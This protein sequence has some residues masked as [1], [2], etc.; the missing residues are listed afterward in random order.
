[1]KIYRFSQNLD[2]IQSLGVPPD[3]AE[4]ILQ[5]V[6]DTPKKKRSVLL[7]KIKK[8]PTLTL[9]QL[10]AIPLSKEDVAKQKELYQWAASISRKYAEWL[11]RMVNKKDLNPE[12]D[13]EKIKELLGRYDKLKQTPDFPSNLANISK[14][15][16]H[17]ELFNAL[18]PYKTRK[19]EISEQEA[20][21]IQEG[22]RVVYNRDGV[23]VTEISTPEASVALC[24]D[25]NWC[26]SD[27]RA[28]KSYLHGTDYPS[29]EP[30]YMFEVDGQKAALAHVPS[31]QIKGV[32]DDVLVDWEIVSR[33]NPAVEE[34][35]L[36]V[37]DYLDEWAVYDEKRDDVTSNMEDDFELYE[38]AVFNGAMLNNGLSNPT[39]KS[40][41]LDKL[42]QIAKSDVFE[43]YRYISNE[44]K[45]IPEVHSLFL[46]QFKQ[47]VLQNPSIAEDMPQEFQEEL[48]D[49]INDPEI[50]RK[51]LSEYHK[52]DRMPPEIKERPDMIE[53]LKEVL[54][55]KEKD[56]YDFRYIYDMYKRNPHLE[57]LKSEVEPHII[58]QAKAKLAETFQFNQLPEELQEN[59]EL[60]SH[61]KD[62]LVKFNPM[63]NKDLI[64]RYE[65]A[66]Q[67]DIP[68]EFFRDEVVRNAY[69]QNMEQIR[70]YKEVQ[71]LRNY[72]RTSYDTKKPFQQYEEFKN[73]EGFAEQAAQIFADGLKELD[74]EGR[75]KP[76]LTAYINTL[77]EHPELFNAPVIQDAIRERSNELAQE[78][79]TPVGFENVVYKLGDNYRNEFI[80]QQRDYIMQLLQNENVTYQ[81]DW[82]KPAALSHQFTSK[83]LANL[84]EGLEN[85]QE[86]KSALID[87]LR[88]HLQERRRSPLQFS[89]L[90]EEI[91]D[92]PE[93]K[94]EREAFIDSYIE[95]IGDRPHGV[96]HYKIPKMVQEDE[97]FRKAYWESL[98]R[99]LAEEPSYGYLTRM[100]V[101]NLIPEFAETKE[102][103]EA[104]REAYA[105]YINEEKTKDAPERGVM[106]SDYHEDHPE[107]YKEAV[108]KIIQ[109]NPSEYPF[110]PETYQ[111]DPE[112]I[113]HTKQAWINHVFQT[114]YARPNYIRLPEILM[115]DPDIMDANRQSV[116][117]HLATTDQVPRKVHSEEFI[118][119]VK[120][121]IMRLL[122]EGKTTP[123][124]IPHS[125]KEDPEIKAKIEEIK[126]RQ[127]AARSWYYK[128]KCAEVI[129]KGDFSKY[130]RDK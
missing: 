19:E 106:F 6:L 115:N 91:Q 60:K 82:N 20:K 18:Q 123:N 110:L 56:I 67:K 87:N 111:K 129:K 43:A 86:L 97:R 40:R 119:Y 49:I 3:S 62:V 85:D 8:N 10:A 11:I 57:K 117:N 35:G 55:E 103:Q 66:Q 31:G 126:N 102:V 23:R 2:Y 88:N 90:P 89:S 122:N 36:S 74:L 125:Y 92:L 112:I 63:E 44:N 95:K 70:I 99:Y 104:I 46:E 50:W 51:Y 28:A 32:D 118:P 77:R 58:E 27:I 12:E 34:L 109:N 83:L 76:S 42:E 114:P 78:S 48:S 94:P 113:A 13:T 45:Q 33:I 39:Y 79:E 108:L 22:S 16:T 80:T 107:A 116:I 24:Q 65:D 15:D 1:M 100:V 120:Q 21:D 64:Y 38:K 69:R 75:W 98:K 127:I 121:C 41:L 84:P 72:V 54:L 68:D 52:Y 93:L 29:N 30:F 101:K 81:Y 14:F 59:E 61:F 7:N 105:R 17:S 9:D 53:R 71:R 37:E 5:F 124:Q 96:M 4:E 47:K 25:T 73:E 128:T 26:V 130:G